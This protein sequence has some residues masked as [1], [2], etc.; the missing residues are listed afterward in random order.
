MSTYQVSRLANATSGPLYHVH[1]AGC[2]DATKRR[3]AETDTVDAG[4]LAELAA[5]IYGVADGSEYT[6]D[7]KVY[8]CAGDL[9]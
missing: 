7:F 9:A 2:G 8:P 1:G 6:S 3:Y 5:D 4:S